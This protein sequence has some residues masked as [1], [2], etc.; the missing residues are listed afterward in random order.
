[1]A[2][3]SDHKYGELASRLTNAADG[4]VNAAASGLERTLRDAADVIDGL[5][6]PLPALPKLVSELA[7][8]A[9]DCPDAATARRLRYLLGEAQ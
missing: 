6:K 7:K 2:N 5:E 1:M 3:P 4:I 8:I 9:N